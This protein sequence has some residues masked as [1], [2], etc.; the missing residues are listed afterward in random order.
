M[1]ECIKIII[2][3]LKAYNRKFKRY[4]YT[5]KVKMQC[6]K[7]GEFLKVNGKSVVTL[8][9]KLGNNVNFN[10]IEIQ[11][12]GRVIIGDNFHSGKECLIITHI[13][14]YDHG[15]CIPYDDTYIHKNVVIE[16]NVW[17]GTRVTIL[18][19]VTIG[20]GAIIQA[21]SVVVKD[22]PKYGIAG[23]SPAKVFKYRDK[24]HYEKL[25]SNGKFH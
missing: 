5:K 25:K 18:G 19:G 10:G 13:H 16:N 7:F 14:N 11:G 8:N 20:E 17:I 12:N 9:T 2:R 4:I 3:K 21:G 6:E 23:G 22:I 1:L 24:E 15:K